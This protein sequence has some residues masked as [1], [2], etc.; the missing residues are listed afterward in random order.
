MPRLQNSTCGYPE[1]AETCWPVHVAILK[2][3]R[4]RLIVCFGNSA[5]SPYTFLRAKLPVTSEIAF[6]S[7]H[8]MWKCRAFWSGRMCVVG[9]PHLSRYAVDRHPRVLR[10]LRSLLGE[11]RSAKQR[12][13]VAGARE[14]TGPRAAAQAGASARR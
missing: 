8:G 2:L 5:V 11:S 14:D 12:L 9:L 3:V 10:R 7:S 4:P 1:L 13:V 6:E